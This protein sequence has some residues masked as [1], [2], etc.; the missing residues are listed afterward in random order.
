MDPATTYALVST[1]A[2]L[3]VPAVAFSALAVAVERR[4]G[5]RWLP[6]LWLAGVAAMVALVGVTLFG[7]AFAL[8]SVAAWRLGRRA[9]HS[10]RP[11]THWVLT[12]AALILGYPVAIAAGIA[13]EVLLVPSL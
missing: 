4:A 5:A 2:A 13:A 3:G 11:V 7:V 9:R 1:A 12:L 6:V 10:R 8:A